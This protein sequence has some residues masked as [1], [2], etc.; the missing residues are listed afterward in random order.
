MFKIFLTN[1]GKYN[2]GQLVG[3]WVDLPCSDFDS[4]LKRI[5]IDGKFYEEFF[6]SAYETDYE[7]KIDEYEDIYYLN[8]LAEELEDLTESET[9]IF[10]AYMEVEDDIDFVL[11]HLEDAVIYY[12]CNDMTDVAYEVVDCNGILDN[13]P[14]DLRNYFDY[15]S[16]GRD[17]KI[18]GTFVEID[19]NIVELYY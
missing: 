5:G 8:N 15:E 19:S 14:D 7:I 6:I 4:V 16:Y 10:R 1:L 12:D 13:I 2:E 17:L 18:S 9:I 11:D 3:E